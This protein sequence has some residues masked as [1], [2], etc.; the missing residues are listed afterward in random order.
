MEHFQPGDWLD[1]ARHL[2]PA[3]TATAMQAHLDRHC[4]QCEQSASIWQRAA[5]VAAREAAYRPPDDLVRIVK[6]AFT[7]AQA[8]TW[9]YRT[10]QFAR[11]M[12]DSFSQPSPAMVRAVAHSSRQLIHQA[13]PYLIDLKL[14]SDPSHKRI[15]L[16][17]QIVNRENPTEQLGVI[18]VVLLRG[19]DIVRKTQASPSGEFDLDFASAEDLQLFINLQ[20]Q[21][22]LGIALPAWES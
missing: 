5:G 13:E 16:V 7:P 21:R 18:D 14:E 10:A 11:L 17:G 22:A 8:A 2:L 19:A 1:F 20:G 6:A 15:F 12:F 9:L 4:P 3:E